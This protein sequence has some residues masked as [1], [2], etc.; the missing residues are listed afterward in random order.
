M[1]AVRTDQSTFFDFAYNIDSIGEP[2]LIPGGALG[3][4]KDAGLQQSGSAF[5]A[6]ANAPTEGYVLD[7]PLVA[8]VGKVLLARSRTQTCVDGT[9]VSWFAKLQVLA[10]DASARTITFQILV[11]QNC[12]YIGLA[13]GLP[14]Q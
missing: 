9:K 8:A 2:V 6:I 3:L 1:V 14:P 11:D 4:P 7:K 10:L 12:G 5:D 13:P